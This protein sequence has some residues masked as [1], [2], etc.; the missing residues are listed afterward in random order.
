M[1]RHQSVRCVLWCSEI[2]WILTCFSAD[3]IGPKGVLKGGRHTYV[4][5]TGYR[6]E[7]C[8]EFS[9]MKRMLIVSCNSHR[10]MTHLALRM[11]S[12]KHHF[13]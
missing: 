6:H 2:F 12:Y 13:Y 11:L 10:I 5:Q 4:Y 7:F 8:F 1:I 3:N 9:T